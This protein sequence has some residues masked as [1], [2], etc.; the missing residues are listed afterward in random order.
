MKLTEKQLKRVIKES[1][2]LALNEGLYEENPTEK[3]T[4]IRSVADALC[5]FLFSSKRTPNY[6]KKELAR[7]TYFNC[8]RDDYGE[9]T[10]EQMPQEVI[11]VVQEAIDTIG[12]AVE[13]SRD[14]IL[15]MVNQGLLDSYTEGKALRAIKD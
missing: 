13:R 5:D 11:E 1:V 3:R 6:L 14:A 12:A 8:S 15:F 4:N 9:H 7:E 10:F 2:K